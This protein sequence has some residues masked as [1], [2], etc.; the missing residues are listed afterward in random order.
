[1]ES[2]QIV[3]TTEVDLG[4][5]YRLFESAIQYQRQKNYPVWQGIDTEV[6]LNDIAHH[7]Q[8]KIICGNEILCIFSV[9]EQDPH[10]WRE[11]SK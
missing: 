5:I 8:Y 4:C 10:I 7:L 9:L 11:R 3:P 6:I 2:F 1:M